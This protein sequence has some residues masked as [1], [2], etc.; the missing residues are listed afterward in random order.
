MGPMR[1]LQCSSS[2]LV[3]VNLVR[4]A[5]HEVGESSYPSVGLGKGQYL[6]FLMLYG[7]LG[8]FLNVLETHCYVGDVTLPLPGLED[9]L[10]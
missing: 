1:S 2:P 5:Q 8:Y 7:S 10:L 6:L 9:N 4:Q 3:C